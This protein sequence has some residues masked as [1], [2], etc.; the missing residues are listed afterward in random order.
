MVPRPAVHMTHALR[1]SGVLLS[2]VFTTWDVDA[3]LSVSVYVGTSF[4]AILTFP[5]PASR[6]GAE[7]KPR[8]V[9]TWVH[10]ARAASTSGRSS[11]WSGLVFSRMRLRLLA[12]CVSTFRM[13]SE[14]RRVGIECRDGI[15]GCGCLS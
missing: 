13:R 15:C 3:G 6:F 8:S 14:E 9:R 1:H 7:R 12:M 4:L 10:A 2:H 11:G 5:A